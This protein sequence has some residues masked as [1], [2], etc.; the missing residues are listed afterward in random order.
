MEGSPVAGDVVSV[1]SSSGEFLAC[2]HYQKDSICVRILSFD[3]PELPKN[4]WYERLQ[5][6]Y[7]ARKASRLV[8]NRDTTC[9][10]LVCGEGDD[11]PGLIIDIYGGTAVVQCHSVGMFRSRSEITDALRQVYGIGLD[12]VYDKSSG[13]APF[14]RN[15]ESS[16][17][18]LW[19]S[20]NYDPSSYKECLE[21]GHR[22]FVDWEKGQKTGFF[23]DQRE[24]RRLV[25]KYASGRNV[26]N[27][28]C[29]TGGF[30]V[31]ALAGGAKHVDSVD[32]SRS[33]ISMLERNIEL[34][35]FGK[36]SSEAFCADAADFLNCSPDG[37]YDMLVLDPPAFA[38]HRAALPNALKAYRHL[39][40]SA[41]SKAAS[42]SFIFT[43][44]C[45]QVVDHDAFALSV[46]SA[47][48]SVGRR[49]KIVDRLN[50][51]ADH[52]VNIYHPEGEYLKGLALYVE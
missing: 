23:L 16:D 9:Y 30:S 22:F 21:H 7:D 49:V 32:S 25:E 38:K 29:Y 52:P 28:F 46:F 14:G 20:A 10:R 27:L 31:Y 51:P 11:L 36:G 19:R 34:N 44:S 37:R 48:A 2:G 26:L 6:A 33:A 47:A 39:N 45:S 43:F 13:T 3:S 50:Q 41:I 17:G 12:A 8:G 40:A 5:A 42:G 1:R 18:Y 35:G 15:N 4:F 24:N